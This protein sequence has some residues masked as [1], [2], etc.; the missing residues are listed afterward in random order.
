MIAGNDHG[1]AATAAIIHHGVSQAITMMDS[2]DASASAGAASAGA[3]DSGPSEH[4]IGSPGKRLKPRS[5]TEAHRSTRRVAATPARWDDPNPQGAEDVARALDRAALA[6]AE[7]KAE[8]LAQQLVEH[9]RWAETE[10]M[11]CKRLIE[12]LK[13]DERLKS[14]ETAAG[15]LPELEK[16]LQHQGDFLD[17]CHGKLPEME[18]QLQ[19]QAEYLA[20][21]QKARPEEEQTLL[22]LFNRLDLQAKHRDQ[23][24]QQAHESVTMQLSTMTVGLTQNQGRMSEV[25]KELEF[26]NMAAM[27][28][29]GQLND[30]AKGLE[31]LQAV[32]MTSAAASSH[33]RADGA[34]T[35]SWPPGVPPPSEERRPRRRF[36]NYN[37]CGDDNCD[38]DHEKK[39][40]ASD[41]A[42][43]SGADCHCHHVD[44]LIAD[45]IADDRLFRAARADIDRLMA[46]DA[47]PVREPPDADGSRREPPFDPW[48][49]PEAA[50]GAGAPADQGENASG[51][52][53][54]ALGSLG[55]LGSNRIFDDRVSVQDDFRLDGRKNGHQWKSKT[56]RYL[57][58][59]VPALS[60]ILRWAERE[61]TAITPAK[62]RE[63]VGRG[64]CTI[65]RDGTHDQTDALSSAL[66]GFLSNCITGEAE[67]MFK[68][69][70]QCAGLDAWRRVIRFIDNGRTIHLEQLR[71]DMRMIRTFPIKNLEGV[72]VGVAAFENKVREFVEAGGRQP[73]EDEM[74]SDLNAILPAELGDHLTLRVTDPH[75][76]F[77]AFREFVVLSCAQLLM[78]KK[79]LPLH[80]VNDQRND[81]P[82]EEEEPGGWPEDA[83]KEREELD[84]QYLAAIRQHSARFGKGGSKGGG[85]GRAKG[86]GKGGGGSLGT[87]QRRCPNCDG[88]HNMSE[89]KL[90]IK[91]K[92][93]RE[94][95]LCKKTG[96]VSANC[97]SKQ[98]R[99]LK[100]IDEGNEVSRIPALTN[101]NINEGPETDAFGFQVVE[102][103]PFRRS[104]PAPVAAASCSH[105]RA[106][107]VPGAARDRGCP[108]AAGPRPKPK[109]TRVT[110]GMHLENAFGALEEAER[111]MVVEELEEINAVRE[112]TTIRVA[113]DSGAVKHVTHP[114]T[115]PSSVKITPNTTG[116]HF[117]GAGG[118]VIE[119]YGNAQAMLTTAE[120]RE[121]IIDTNV[122]EVSRPLHAVSQVTGPADHPTG[123]QDVLFTNKRCVVVQPGVVEHILKYIKPIAQYDRDGNLYL[124]T[125]TVSDFVRPGPGQ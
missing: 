50:A 98:Q 10:L 53:P 62:L 31:Q 99:A 107:K 79:R 68:Q 125:M 112:R 113:M 48:R 27:K 32:P 80:N 108:P 81:S 78:R 65:D 4:F 7:A 122:A 115:L 124:A 97:P 101:W 109:T 118:E 46:R 35:S 83:A 121:I 86:G 57:I 52:L 24:H 11:A 67:V 9:K 12:G 5:P 106:D 66:W 49:R 59:K 40:S 76:S 96:H 61:E 82:T 114:S 30:L 100:S 120:G 105:N 26:V 56:E 77:A 90:P 38:K 29:Q 63:A 6:Q 69:A 95:W 70:E 41:N 19:R 2:T 14:L 39:G 58:S 64:L 8:A 25:I 92:A 91:D 111:L 47:A 117:S 73:P 45:A 28:T 23:Q 54:L 22:A 20:I 16:R 110:F 71:N 123:K 34:P 55:S 43:G 36:G 13:I 94:C 21:F 84:Q 103:R 102:K 72:A 18:A 17:V 1:S 75:Q 3:H 116:K 33:N 60:Q 87:G 44:R 104:T 15:K 51:G 93:D 37:G 74:K 119:R 42:P 85:K 88:A 89:C